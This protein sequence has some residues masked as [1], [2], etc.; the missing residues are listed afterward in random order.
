MVTLTPGGT[1]DNSPMSL[2]T[3]APAKKLSAIKSVYKFSKLLDVKQKM[4]SAGS[5]L[6]HQS[7]KL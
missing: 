2:I 5:V 7:S 1:T 4:M 6:L 3:L